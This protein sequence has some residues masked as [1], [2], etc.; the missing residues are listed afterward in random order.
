MKTK[1]VFNS[2]ISK[3]K[4]IF[5]ELLNISIDI[6]E[7]IEG[8]CFYKHNSFGDVAPELLPK[9]INIYN[10][11]SQATNILEIGFNA[12]HSCLL[13]LL[14]N[15]TSKITLFDICEHKYTVPCFMYLKT[16]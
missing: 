12:G 5:D 1:A 16:S 7:S 2:I 4:Y 11:S 3:Y 13:M 15:S 10:L 8:N 14:S 9:Q 6:G